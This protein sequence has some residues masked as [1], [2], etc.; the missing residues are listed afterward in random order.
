MTRTV[1]VICTDEKCL[2]INKISVPSNSGNAYICSNSNCR[3]PLLPAGQFLPLRRIGKGA[4][5][6][7]FLAEDL[8]VPNTPF[9][10]KRCRLPCGPSDS[11]EAVSLVQLNQRNIVRFY[12]TF[13]WQGARFYVME[14]IDGEDLWKC[15]TTPWPESRV[16][17]L[18]LQMLDA[19][20]EMALKDIVHCDIQPSNIM[21]TRHGNGRYHHHASG[22][23]TT[24]VPAAEGMSGGYCRRGIAPVYTSHPSKVYD[25]GMPSYGSGQEDHTGLA[26][27][28]EDEKFVLV[29]FGLSRGRGSYGTGTLVFTN[30]SAPEIPFGHASPSSD[31]WSLGATIVRL[32]VSRDQPAD[33][34]FFTEWAPG[35]EIS[36]RLGAVLKKMLANQRNRYQNPADA[37]RDLLDVPV[38][39]RIPEPWEI[40]IPGGKPL[41][42]YFAVPKSTETLAKDI[43]HT[44]MIPSIIAMLNSA[45]QQSVLYV[46][47][48]ENREVVGLRVPNVHDFELVFH[49]CISAELMAYDGYQRVR[50]LSFYPIGGASTDLFIVR[51]VVCPEPGDECL[52]FT[53]HK[54]EHL[55]YRMGDSGPLP[56]ETAHHLVVYAV[57]KVQNYI[58]QIYLRFEDGAAI[59]DNR[60]AAKAGPVGGLEKV[61]VKL[62]GVL[63]MT[64]VPLVVDYVRKMILGE[65][66]R[67]S[68]T[69][70][71]RLSNFSSSSSSSSTSDTSRGISQCDPRPSQSNNS[72]IDDGYC[73]AASDYSSTDSSFPFLRS[74]SSVSSSSSSPLIDLHSSIDDGYI[75]PP[76]QTAINDMN[77]NF[78]VLGARSGSVILDLSMPRWAADLL[79]SMVA[80]S[81]IRLL[82]IGFLFMQ[83]TNITVMLKVPRMGPLHRLHDSAR[84]GETIFVDSRKASPCQLSSM[85]LLSDI[86]EST[87]LGSSTSTIEEE[88]STEPPLYA[89]SR[90][91]SAG[92]EVVGGKK[93]VDLDE[94]DEETELHR[95]A[96][97]LIPILLTKLRQV[98]PDSSTSPA[99]LRA[100]ENDL[101]ILQGRLSSL[102]SHRCK[103]HELR[104]LVETLQTIQET[105]DR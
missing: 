39:R 40:Q 19:L 17:L 55:T 36:P 14:W 69:G 83:R 62:Q 34:F 46:G 101:R 7:T 32:L 51:C 45:P 74:P 103:S 27:T 22:H 79:H 21:V 42:S 72:I 43:I 60:T 65:G 63:S 44:Y 70:G 75:L 81:D 6:Q 30:F 13:E 12:R 71:E 5:G 33:H 54:W 76:F 53:L 59:P 48:D 95:L 18:L 8:E 31:L 9:A 89:A 20:W 26:G 92:V 85:A 90:C 93:P 47:V 15:Y 99:H 58:Q 16:R 88:K 24:T 38:P 73:R 64:E 97:T 28:D 78:E 35:L 84:L 29:D 98:A 2:A 82:C 3:A 100:V 41:S 68:V 105:C 80:T 104:S 67:Q 96:S 66:A 61:M 1:E 49:S 86:L 25:Q 57:E 4:F 94:R 56:I 23:A 52:A 11:N 102:S 50:R 91:E 87:T 37:K 77:K 10:L